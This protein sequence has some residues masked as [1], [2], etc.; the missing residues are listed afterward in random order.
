VKVRQ[1]RV[2][3]AGGY[4]CRAFKNYGL[5]GVLNSINNFYSVATKLP[6]VHS[7]P[8]F[9]FIEPTIRCNLRCKM[10]DLSIRERKK[11]ETLSFFEFKEVVEQFPFC[12]HIHLQGMGEPFLNPELLKMVRY[13]AS[14]RIKI[15]TFTNGTIMTMG[16]AEEI[17]SSG[18]EEL[19]ISLDGATKQ[20]YEGIRIGADFNKVLENI[21]LLLDAKGKN[22]KPEVGI[23][24]VAMK[25]NIQEFPLLVELAAKL[26]IQRVCVEA[27][28]DWGKKAVKKKINEEK[29]Q[30]TFMSV[31]EYIRKALDVSKEK[32]VKLEFNSLLDVLFNLGQGRKYTCWAPWWSCFITADG[33]VTPCCKRPDPR[34][35]NFGNVFEQNF[36]VIWNSPQYM[37]FRQNLKNGKPPKVCIDC[38]QNGKLL[39]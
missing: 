32:G 5:K 23:W 10:C 38:W 9:I 27:V 18:L 7:T 4:I 11:G 30:L 6:K 17:V 15:S 34:V 21:K 16:L 31:K 8:L 33:Y 1:R 12:V 36:K 14:K 13:A 29:L 25:E 24:F 22:R 3:I 39:G 35:F 26:G 37:A 2:E 19:W 28:D 20:T